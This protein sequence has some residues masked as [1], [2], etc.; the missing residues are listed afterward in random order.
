VLRPRASWWR[1]AIAGAAL[2]ALAAVAIIVPWRGQPRTAVK[3]LPS[4]ARRSLAVIPPRDDSGDSQSAWLATALGDIVTTNLLASS[5]LT[6]ASSTD[7]ARMKTDLRLGNVQTWSRAQ[8][9]KVRTDLGAEDVIAGSYRASDGQVRVDVDIFDTATGLAVGKATATSPA[10][11]LD[12]LGAR[13]ALDIEQALGVHADGAGQVAAASVLP[14]RPTAAR[15]Y[16]E[17]LAHLRRFETI[18]ARELLQRAADEDSA[19]PLIH[20]AL[21]DTWRTLGYDAKAAA[22]AK[23]A[24]EHSSQLPKE[25]RL[26][27]EAQYHES[28]H[29]WDQA[30]EAYHTLVEFF[31]TRLDYGLALAAAQTGAGDAKSAYATLDGFRKLPQ[32]SGDPRIEIAEADAAESADDMERERVHAERAV[33][34]ARARGARVLLAKALFRHG[35]AL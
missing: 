26:A 11:E 33:S 21:A 10:G 35:W 20:A 29:Q 24:Y 19:D 28:L 32:L 30:I 8:L 17:G 6:V 9:L 13:L 3:P 4:G 1:V 2:L 14:A 27:I 12:S 31:P 16:S 22:E 18:P 23:L 34:L 15:Y 25:N 7:V 5:Q